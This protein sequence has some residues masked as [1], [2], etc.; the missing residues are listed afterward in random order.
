M[1]LFHVGQ[2]CCFKASYRKMKKK[3]D[4]FKNGTQNVTRQHTSFAVFCCPSFFYLCCC[5]FQSYQCVVF[6]LKKLKFVF[7][8]FCF[9]LRQ[10]LKHHVVAGSVSSSSLQNNGVMQS[11]LTTPLRVK[12]YESEDSEWRPLKVNTKVHHVLW[13]GFFLLLLLKV[14]VPLI[15]GLVRSTPP[16]FI[17]SHRID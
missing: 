1:Y 5:Q 3:K 13:L 14:H 12:F 15:C 16:V 10:L 9:D 17:H 6:S 4:F 7:W 8:C 2:E 11:L